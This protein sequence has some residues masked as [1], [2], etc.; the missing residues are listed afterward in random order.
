MLKRFILSALLAAVL[1][2][3]PSINAFS[4]WIGVYA[5]IDKVVVEPGTG[6]PERIQIWGDFAL[7]KTTDRNTYESPQRGYL[8][9]KIVPGKEEV[10]RKEWADL[11]ALA[12][13]G[14]VIGFG[15]RNAF[16]SNPSSR[17]R[18]RKAD[19]KVADPEPYLVGYG[20][21]KM[22]DRPSNYEPIRELKALTRPTG[23]K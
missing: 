19:E 1:A 7:A 15:A 14:Q 3:A 21:V 5:V 4:D 16:M 18:I 11:K 20:M 10:C 6:A 23:S 13:T 9:L 22:G 17:P 2:S 8:Y 12:G